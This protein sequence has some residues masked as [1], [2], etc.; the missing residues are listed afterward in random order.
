[1]ALSGGV[2]QNVRLLHASI[3]RLERADFEVYTHHQ[4]PSND[5][6]LALGQAAVA[7]RLRSCQEN[8]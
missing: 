5:G 6:G 8:G 7:A 3:A 4:V 1:V 2:F